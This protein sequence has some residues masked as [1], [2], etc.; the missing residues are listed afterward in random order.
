MFSH[1]PFGTKLAPHIQT[2]NTENRNNVLSA[3]TKSFLSAIDKC[4]SNDSSLQL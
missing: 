3:V 2:V 4:K 1:H